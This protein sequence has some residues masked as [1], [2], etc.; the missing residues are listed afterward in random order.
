MDRLTD[1]QKEILRS[2]CNIPPEDIEVIRLLSQQTQD[3]LVRWLADN[4]LKKLIPFK[5]SR[6]YYRKILVKVGLFPLAPAFWKT[7]YLTPEE[8]CNYVS[9]L[10]YAPW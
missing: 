10:D 6:D 2:Q 5:N 8:Y 3:N 9:L 1:A 7:D 4:D